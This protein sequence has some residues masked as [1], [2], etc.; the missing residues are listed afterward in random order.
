M[1]VRGDGRLVLVRACGQWHQE[2]AKEGV[3]DIDKDVSYNHVLW[4]NTFLIRTQMDGKYCIGILYLFFI[5]VMPSTLESSRRNSVGNH[6]SSFEE[7]IEETVKWYLENQEWM[8][9]VTSG[10]YQKYY[11]EMYCK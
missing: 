8:D 4:F 2:F 10:E 7:G 1:W 5:R 11:E 3:G 6:L 9:H